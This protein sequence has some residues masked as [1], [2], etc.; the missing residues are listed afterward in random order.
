MER[1]TPIL[2]EKRVNEQVA[3]SAVVPTAGPQ[4]S[5][6]QPA[7]TP[8]LHCPLYLWCTLLG[9]PTPPDL[10]LDRRSLE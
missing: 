1:H 8:A 10:R 7:R 3:W 4:A 9:T 2:A 6:L 5:R